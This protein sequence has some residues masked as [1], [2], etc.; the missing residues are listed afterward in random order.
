[1]ATSDGP[2]VELYVSGGLEQ[3]CST[4]RLVRQA[5]GLAFP[6]G[7]DLRVIDAVATPELAVSAGVASFPS[8][9]RLRPPP[10]LVVHLDP[11]D[12]VTAESLAQDLAS[13]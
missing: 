8:L 10:M 2:G 5:V 1:V 4:V 6:G 13:R 3:V 9:L 11:A 12:A 7:C